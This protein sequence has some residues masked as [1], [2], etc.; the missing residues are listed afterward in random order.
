MLKK[1]LKV[2]WMVHGYAESEKEVRSKGMVW[3]ENY[4]KAG[5]YNYFVSYPYYNGAVRNIEEVPEHVLQKPF[6]I[7]EKERRENG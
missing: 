6:D 2:L 4:Y 1:S 7:R 5:R 3:D